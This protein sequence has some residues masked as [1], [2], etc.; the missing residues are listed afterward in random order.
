MNLK[1]PNPSLKEIDQIGSL[2]VRFDS[3]IYTVSNPK[4]LTDAT[5]LLSDVGKSRT[6]KGRRASINSNRVPV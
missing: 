4:M 3:D 5:I 6:L 2:I 1:P